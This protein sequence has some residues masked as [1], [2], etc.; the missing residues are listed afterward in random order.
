MLLQIDNRGHRDPGVITAGV[1]IV[2]IGN[3]GKY[4]W[5]EARSEPNRI[6]GMLR[7]ELESDAP[8][9]GKKENDTTEG[10]NWLFD[11]QMLPSIV[12]NG[13][14]WEFWYPQKDASLQKLRRLAQVFFQCVFEKCTDGQPIS[15]IAYGHGGL[16]L[17]LG[18]MLWYDQVLTRSASIAPIS[19][20]SATP[21]ILAEPLPGP[22]MTTSQPGTAM[23]PQTSKKIEDGS[24][25]REPSPLHPDQPS[26][27]AASKPVGS[28]GETVPKLSTPQGLGRGS[29]EIPQPRSPVSE[30][31]TEPRFS[32]PLADI[33]SIV[34]GIILLGSPRKAP[35]VYLK[36][37]DARASEQETIWDNF[38]KDIPISKEVGINSNDEHLLDTLLDAC[39]TASPF[40]A[41]S[42]S[43]TDKRYT[44]YHKCFE[45]VVNDIGLP[46]KC[47]KGS[48]QLD[49]EAGD[50]FEVC[51][52][53]LQLRS[54][55]LCYEFL[56]I[57][58]I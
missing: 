50:F 31:N 2:A 17:E 16:I 38:L 37:A 5:Q 42:K 48:D 7:R 24:E 39:L 56:I 12:P 6:W 30:T 55:S 25:L 35:M 20:R 54:L 45:R 52:P 46:T 3:G 4:I 58:L 8:R 51:T 23:L 26:T 21:G 33:E 13:R 53:D 19:I 27:S 47:Y 41:W 44:L 15:F 18:I 34:A 36:T 22:P 9:R 1:D 32:V 57:H 40:E 10:I 49:P 29:E 14:L 43:K 28:E 11:Q